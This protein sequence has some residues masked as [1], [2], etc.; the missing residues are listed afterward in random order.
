MTVMDIGA[1]ALRTAYTRLQTTSHNIANASTP[2]YS[3]QETQVASVEAQY[4]SGGFIGGG[5][6]VQTVVRQYDQHLTR[7]VHTA[8]A[9]RGANQARADSL[10]RLDRMFSNTET[11]LGV[12]YDE[13][14]ASL[15]DLVNQ[16]FDP[17]ARTV[18]LERAS[19]LANSIG[20]ADSEIDRLRS[21]TDS[22]A[23]QLIDQLNDRLAE[24]A[25]LNGQIAT[26]A[27]SEHAPNDLLDQR[28]ALIEN[29]NQVLQA[30]THINDDHTVS[31]FAAT[32]DA[33][34]LADEAVTLA[35]DSEAENPEHLRLTM[36]TQGEPLPLNQSMLGG[37]ELSGLLMYR[38]EDLTQARTRLGQMAGALGTAYNTQ[39]GLG[40]DADG[41]A[42]AALFRLGRATAL[43]ASANTGDANVAIAIADGSA[44]QAS[45][46]KLQRISGQF[47][48]TRIS[49]GEQTTTGAVPV[50][51]DG[52]DISIQS[53]AMSDGDTI[54]LKT[55]S[56]FA[57]NFEVAMRSPAQWA[58]A[59][60]PIA[61]TGEQNGGSLTL[62][63]FAVTQVD[64]NVS[65]PVSMVF[66]GS[67]MV[68]VSGPG[69]GDPAPFAWQPGEPISF[70]GWT[71]TLAGEPVA[72]DTIAVGPTTDPQADNRNARALLEL[73]EQ[74]IIDGGSPSQAV[75]TLVGEVGARSMTAATNAQQSEAW[76]ASAVA[77]RNE[78]SGV[79]L[80]EEAARLLQY[81]QA[82]QAA[83]RLISTSQTMF[84][85]LMSATA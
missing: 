74:S 6:D 59:F 84:D 1:S 34:V 80:D 72:G 82:Y 19:N 13:F 16:P 64:P 55:G 14:N 52:L 37:G 7:E 35:L 61:Q 53:G 4:G 11:G 70:N 49:D 12:R 48:V 28:D 54:L 3:R 31:L 45:D 10:A 73:S 30:S 67:G 58:T 68:L 71:M 50:T 63:D 47:V 27:G 26:S 38:N 75:G 17:A 36:L 25:R 83:A 8:S 40:I 42:G 18:A 60:A 56:A 41:N 76:H 23:G 81:Q 39:Q 9:V 15:A 43:P 79:N 85:S 57:G 62:T 77:A 32:G 66:N 33:L 44:L 21:D 29:I 69:T 22:Q 24:V 78:V 20:S 2:G 65:E 5:V 46:Y 51:I